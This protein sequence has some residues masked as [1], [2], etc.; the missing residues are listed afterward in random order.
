MST[1][2]WTCLACSASNEADVGVCSTCGCPARS[3][4]EQQ[5]AFRDA[6]DGKPPRVL[7]PPTTVGRNISQWV[8]WP[9]VSTPAQARS[10]AAKGAA[11]AGLIALATLA[12]SLYSAYGRAGG[13]WMPSSLVDVG[14]FLV[15]AFGIWRLSRVAAVVGL[16]LYLGERIY[17]LVTLGHIPSIIA[18]FVMLFLFHAVRG[19]FAYHRLAN[20]SAAR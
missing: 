9:D 6:A 4:V 12:M 3:T 18:F 2:R 19:T 14:V 1:Y 8:F 15:I 11:V 10:T 17:L 13:H 16:T 7:E 5:E 20:D